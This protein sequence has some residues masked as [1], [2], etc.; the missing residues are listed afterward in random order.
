M[1][2][3]VTDRD[4]Q[5]FFLPEGDCPPEFG[6]L[7]RGATPVSLTGLATRLRKSP[8][9]DLDQELLATLIERW[10]GRPHP[11]ADRT[12]PARAIK[13]TAVI[14]L[15]GIIRHLGNLNPTFGLPEA[16]SPA[17]GFSSDSHLFSTHSDSTE[18]SFL[19]FSDGGCRLAAD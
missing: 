17:P 3:S 16:D 7:P 19:D 5:G 15:G 1:G 12:R 2:R 10:A 6:R 4:Q 11:K 8:P 9:S 14:G 13:T 18:V